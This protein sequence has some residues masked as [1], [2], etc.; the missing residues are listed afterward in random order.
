MSRQYDDVKTRIKIHE[1]FK[2]K[3]YRLSY[4]VLDDKGQSNKV[5]EDFETGG[6]G[7]RMI[8]GEELPKTENG[9]TNWEQVFEDD[10]NKALEGAGSLLD[11][12]TT[13]SQAFGIITEMCYQMGAGGVAKFKNCLQAIREGDY[14][15]A[16]IEMMDSRW[17]KQTPER[18]AK[19]AAEM[20]DLG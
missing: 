17:A 13:N 8:A 18:A 5:T 19:M 16:S 10:F 11:E 9:E 14:E 15:Q 1:G 4:T 3:P 6:Y 20:H 7:H 12:K 2:D